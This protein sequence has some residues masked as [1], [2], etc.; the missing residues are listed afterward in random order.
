MLG[1]LL[2]RHTSHHFHADFEAGAGVIA[3]IN[4]DIPANGSW[5]AW[6]A[7]TRRRAQAAGELSRIATT[8]A[9][10]GASGDR[11]ACL[12][13]QVK[14]ARRGAHGTRIS[15]LR[16]RSSAAPA[17]EKSMAGKYEDT[18]SENE[19]VADASRAAHRVVPCRMPDRPHAGPTSIT[20]RSSRWT[21]TAAFRAHAVT[22][23]DLRA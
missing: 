9:D 2:K 10:E 13:V 3:L 14:I 16:Q 8:A 5:L 19:H 22:R 17:R 4:A 18:G 11:L 6:S 20:G 23:A 21:D 12:L 1:E 15:N 7:I